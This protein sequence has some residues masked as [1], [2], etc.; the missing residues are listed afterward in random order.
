LGGLGIRKVAQC[1]RG[2]DR[3]E[4]GRGLHR[5]QHAESEAQHV[6]AGGPPEALDDPVGFLPFTF[7][8]SWLGCG[9]GREFTWYTGG[10]ALSATLEVRFEF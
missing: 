8:L 5:V 2:P 7:T 10:D 1:G 3:D 4:Q 9:A 6:A